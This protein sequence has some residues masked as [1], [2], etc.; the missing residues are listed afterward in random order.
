M[1]PALA[2]T[3]SKLAIWED[4]GKMTKL[5]LPVLENVTPGMARNAT[6]ATSITVDWGT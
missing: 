2:S 6:F 5:P 4:D 3:E 1:L